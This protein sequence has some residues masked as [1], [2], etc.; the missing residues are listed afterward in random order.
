M[1][2]NLIVVLPAAAR[3]LLSGLI[4]TY[5]PVG[6]EDEKA[7]K[8]LRFVTLE[9]FTSDISTRPSWYPMA[10]NLLLGLNVTLV[11][12]LVFELSQPFTSVGETRSS[13]FQRST[14]LLMDT[15]KFPFGA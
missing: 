10:I 9:M 11:G 6:E 8:V 14:V 4:A 3:T 12:G 15:I 2:Q 13:V 5:M 1:S 7:F